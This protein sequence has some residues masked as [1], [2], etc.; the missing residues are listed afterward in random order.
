MK[1]STP[2]ESGS[3]H[4]RENSQAVQDEEQVNKEDDERQTTSDSD[5]LVFSFNDEPC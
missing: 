3:R 1:D 5:S 2:A 4:N